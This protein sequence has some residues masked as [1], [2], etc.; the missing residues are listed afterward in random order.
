[1]GKNNQQ[2]AGTVFNIWYS[3]WAGGD[4]F[5]SNSEERDDMGGVGSFEKDN[6]TLYIGHLGVVG[7]LEQT[8]YRHFSEWGDIEQVRVL[9]SKGVAFVRYRFRAAA[10]FAKE[11]MYCQS[12]DQNEILNVRWATE[13]PNPKA[14]LERK[15][16]AEE[17]FGDALTKNLPRL[18]EEGATV[19]DFANHYPSATD[20]MA[21]GGIQ[22][23]QGIQQAQYAQWYGQ[24]GYAYPAGMAG[25][26]YPPLPPAGG[27]A[28]KPRKKKKKAEAP[29][30]DQ[31]RSEAD[32][33]EN[34]EGQEKDA[35]EEEEE[36]ETAEE[37]KETAPAPPQKA[38]YSAP[39]VALK[40]G[41]IV[42]SSTIQYLS[43]MTERTKQ[44][45]QQA[46][47]A[48]KKAAP[49]AGFGLIA[50]YG[51]DEDDD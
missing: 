16:K 12:M 25:Y 14:T 33:A 11:A 38:V 10:E 3:K 2:P 27:E 43:M 47:A 15:R 45:K 13:D 6:R 8:V 21:A 22:Q 49:G 37:P 17:Q 35:E 4:R 30:P 19:L 18:D 34:D 26:G 39:P 50:G 32:D 23:Y 28:E 20:V 36:E 44:L 29:E 31:E 9:S 7:G 41:S 42:S 46:A 51:S 1:M 48:S 5:N 24:A 40:H